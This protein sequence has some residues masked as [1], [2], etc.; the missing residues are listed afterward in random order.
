MFLKHLGT[1]LF[2]DWNITVGKNTDMEVYERILPLKFLSALAIQYFS[3]LGN[4]YRAEK[5]L[6]NQFSSTGQLPNGPSPEYANDSS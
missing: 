3:A 5:T 6:G 4:M 1:R 2:S